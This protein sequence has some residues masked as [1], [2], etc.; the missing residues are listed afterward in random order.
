MKG[1]TV[2][3]AVLVA[4]LALA[5]GFAIYDLVSRELALSAVATQSQYAIYAADT[6]VECALYWD[7]K[8]PVLNG[9]RSAFG[10]SSSASWAPSGIDCAGVDITS[11]PWV[12]S[13]TTLLAATTT[14]TLRLGGGTDSDPCVDVEVGKNDN[15]TTRSTIVNAYGHNNCATTGILRVERQLQVNY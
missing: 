5:I 10:T 1:F 11:I 6:G 12:H 3:F 2:Y 14:F 13:E 15:G 7:F 8:A 9:V 4:S